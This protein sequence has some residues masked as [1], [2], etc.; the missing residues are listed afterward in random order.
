MTGSR[1]FRRGPLT[2]L[3]ALLAGLA[4]VAAA[5]GG[6]DEDSSSTTTGK[7]TT[8]TAAASAGA[9]SKADI[10][11]L[12]ANISGGGASFPDAFYQAVNADFNGV[13]GKE[14]VAYAKSG[15]SDGRAQLAAGTLDYAGSDSLPKP[16]ET[17]GG[18]KVLFFPTVAAPITVSYN[19]D[20][21]D[22]LKLSQETVAKI[23]SAQ[24]TSW[25][26]PAI[27]ADNPDA[28]LPSTP[29]VV[30][31]RSDGSGT[32]NNF[33]KF[34][35][36]AAPQ[37]WTLGSGDTVNW[38]A[39][40]QGAE[41]N[42]GVAQL[43]SQTAG[44]VGY[45]DLADAVKADLTFAEIENAAGK[46]VGPTADGVKSA[47]DSAEVKDDLT[48]DPLNASGDKSYAITAPT[49]ILVFQ[50]Q[51]DAAKAQTLRTYLQ[52]LLTTGQEQAAANAYVALPSGLDEKALA[53]ID[54]ITG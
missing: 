18:K 39:G 42:S 43:I 28:D 7:E 30:V 27:A 41:K 46:F 4:L 35:T 33:T 17:F 6:S 11:A 26:D 45:V 8:T 36:K 9:P 10:T 53:Q 22:E 23:F 47:L 5:C 40:T 16:E 54:Q 52:Y 19:L 32:T 25:D 49:W 13:A 15:S 12:T 20:G 51:T 21:V 24:I 37:T 38:P 50:D 48:Y 44:A 31:H 29:I 2:L 3:V 14:L 34:L 1:Q